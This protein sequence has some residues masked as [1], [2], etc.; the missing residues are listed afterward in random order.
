MAYQRDGR[1]SVRLLGEDVGTSWCLAFGREMTW[2][3]RQRD[4]YCS[5]IGRGAGNGGVREIGREARG[6]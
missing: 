4:R 1:T 3:R 2:G 5:G 6:E